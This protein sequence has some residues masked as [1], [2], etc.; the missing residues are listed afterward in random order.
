MRVEKL[1][2]D[3]VT[4][5]SEAINQGVEELNKVKGVE[6]VGVRRKPRLLP[7]FPAYGDSG[8]DPT[9]LEWA[10]TTYTALLGTAVEFPACVRCFRDT[11]DKLKR[12]KHEA[13]E[14]QIAYDRA[15]QALRDGQEDGGV[16][17]VGSR[18]GSSDE[19]NVWGTLYDEQ[20]YQELVQEEEQLKALLAERQAE[21]AI[22][23][24]Q[25]VEAATQRNRLEDLKRRAWAQLHAEEWQG[26]EWDDEMQSVLTRRDRY[27][28]V[29]RRMKRFNVCNDAFFLW[30]DGPFATIN[31][32]R[33]GRLPTQPVEWSEISAALGQATLLLSSIARKAEFRFSTCT[34]SPL[35]SFSKISTTGG[36]V[37]PLHSDGSFL[38]RRNFERG[39]QC[40]LGCVGEM[41][42]FVERHDP[43]V[44]LPFRIQDGKIGDIPLVL[45]NDERWTRALKFMLI[46]LKWM[47]AWTA[48][49]SD[50]NRNRADADAAR[51]AMQQQQ[52]RA[53]QRAA[54]AVAAAAVVENGAAGGGG[55]AGGSSYDK[56]VTVV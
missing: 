30:H 14:E 16:P 50:A 28:T 2:N 24:Q 52:A 17:G 23:K 37:Y 38:R 51:A 6:D 40:F 11:N 25:R 15:L 10:K 43:T 31:G 48:K 7:V 12:I 27:E 29:L 3:E 35:G 47:L 55:G 42:A 9:A 46:D 22:V 4:A 49:H 5:L 53:A 32:F 26:Q 20:K 56:G 13:E 36:T 21:L 54:A 45:G 19:P 33:L 39:V 18:V 8:S 34:L 1:P 41:G 44:Q